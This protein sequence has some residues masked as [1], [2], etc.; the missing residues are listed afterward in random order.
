MPPAHETAGSDYTIAS[1]PILA[2]HIN[3]AAPHLWATGFAASIN[4]I[5]VLSIDAGLSL[6]P[7]VQLAS[8]VF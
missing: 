8:A 5:A 2:P 6:Q 1:S 4:R 3:T 7:L